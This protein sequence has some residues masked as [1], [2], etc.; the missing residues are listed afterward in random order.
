VLN[1]Q[2]AQAPVAGLDA[3]LC[4]TL[5][6]PGGGTWWID[7]GGAFAPPVGAVAA[8]ITAP[9]LSFPDWGTQRSGWRDSD[10]TITG[11]ADLASRFLDRVNVV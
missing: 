4:L 6:G 1:N 8:Q 10:V 2:V 11:D 3:R 5:T 9:A 7:E